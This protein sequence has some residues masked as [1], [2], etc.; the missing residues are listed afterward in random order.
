[1]AKKR[2][3]DI[4][5]LLFDTE[6]VTTLSLRGL[7]LYE[8]LWGVAEDWGGLELKACDLRLRM[9]AVKITTQEV[10]REL[11]KLT[12]KIKKII[13]YQVDSKQ[14]GWLK[15]FLK[16]QRLSNPALPVLPLPEWIT[17]EV[18]EYPSKKKYAI[19]RVIQEKLP[20]DYQ[21]TTS[22]TEKKPIETIPIETI[23]IE[24]REVTAFWDYYL[25]KTKK[26]FKLTEDKRSLI[27]KRLGDYTLEQLKQA[28]D[29][30]VADDWEG[31]ADHM[32]L[33]YCIGKQKGKPD[34]LEKWLN[35]KR[36]PK[37]EF[38]NVKE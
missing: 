10:E 37:I 38:E 34:N 8:V 20:V 31:R 11:D 35:K 3:L 36:K 33:V 14:Y 23:P 30:F 15:N 28:V 2:T 22:N 19:Y 6:L 9:G 16:N 17:Y 32:D 13:P 24:T 18:K 7:I 12:N 26:A 29:N 4:E 27:A 5:G 25:L 1:M 21:Y